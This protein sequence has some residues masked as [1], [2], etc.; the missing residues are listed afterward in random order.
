MPRTLVSSVRQALAWLSDPLANRG[1]DVIK[2]AIL[3]AEDPVFR[4]P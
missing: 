3:T 1:C 4:Q 2:T